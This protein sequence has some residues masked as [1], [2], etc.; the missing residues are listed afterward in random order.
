MFLLLLM[1][2]IMKVGFAQHFTTVWTGN[3]FQPMNILVKSATVDDVDLGA[4]DEIAVFDV[5]GSGNE[6]CVGV[7]VL[8][9]TINS[10]APESINASLDDNTTSE[11][12][13][14][15]DGH[16]IIF[17]LWDSDQQI[18]ID[19]VIV[20]YLNLE[21]G[22]SDT[23]LSLGTAMVNIEGS[24]VSTNYLVQD[25]TVADGETE[26]YNAVKT[27]T[28]AGS[29]TTVDIQS[30]GTANFIAGESILLEPGFHAYSGSYIHA[31]I[32]TTG[33]YCSSL[34]PIVE[35]PGTI[36]K[37]IEANE[38]LDNNAEMKIYP[39]PTTGNFTIDFKGEET[40]ADILLLNFQGRTLMEKKCKDQM[41]I[42][43]NIA[44][45]PTG[46]YILVIKTKTELITKKIIKNF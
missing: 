2:L 12:D 19:S 36:E 25:I 16:E 1:F 18:E 11:M 41:K 3:P 29:E 33:D 7:I 38:I 26:C 22:F 9:G 45:L 39:N 15:T 17:R 43:L 10:G 27:I 8:T 31:Y 35:N 13:G 5:D 37:D 34:P 21:Y 14:F 24:S 32:T 6:I 30:G 28:V 4:G 46:I 23:Y 20:S 44:Y 40:T 42:D